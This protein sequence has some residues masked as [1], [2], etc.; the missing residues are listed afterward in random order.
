MIKNNWSKDKY[1][2]IDLNSVAKVVDEEYSPSAIILNQLYGAAITAGYSSSRVE[3]LFS[4]RTRIDTI[5][6]R[7]QTPYRQSELTHLHFEREMT[8]SIKFSDFVK[9]WKEKPRK[10]LLI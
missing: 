3:C 10:L 6:R 7:Q 5:H 8:K 1:G 2:Q 9:K 4:A